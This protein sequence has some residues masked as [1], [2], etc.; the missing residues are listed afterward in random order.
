MN[1]IGSKIACVDGVQQSTLRHLRARCS[2]TVAGIRARKER[3]RPTRAIDV[4]LKARN[5]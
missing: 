3:R 1:P 5:K 4:T 2:G